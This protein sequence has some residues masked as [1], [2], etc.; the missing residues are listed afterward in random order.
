MKQVFLLG[1]L[2]LALLALSGCGPTTIRTKPDKDAVELEAKKQKEFAL[3]EQLHKQ[4]RLQNTGWPVL[5]AGVPLC[6]DRKRW[7]IGAFYANKHDFPEELQDTAASMLNMDDEVQVMMVAQNSPAVM[8]GIQKGDVLIS[9]NGIATPAG[10]E[11]AKQLS[12]LLKRELDQGKEADLVVRR[13]GIQESV[14]VKPVEI[15]DYPLAL[16]NQNEINAY[17]DGNNIIVFS[18]LMDFARTDQE[19]SLIL[20]HELSHNAM[21]H[22]DAKRGNYLIGMLFDILIV[23][24]TGVDFGVRNLTA[25]TY[26]QQF[27]AEADYVGLYI[28]ARAGIPLENSADIWRRMAASNPDTIKKSFLAS[29][30]STPE[31][32]VAMENTVREIQE[33][34]AN[35]TDLMPNIDENALQQ[36][37]TVPRP[38]PPAVKL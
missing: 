17:A 18:G 5:T 27:E 2:V 23:G 33:K 29:H 26:S 11:A 32:F 36:R 35:H 31:R 34:I 22:M 8:G 13:N 24:A 25:M 15:C 9:I 30:P 1:F 21:R 10:K 28:M 7:S 16:L 3:R 20:A 37:E 19:L 6:W 4:E 14:H 38:D 12:E